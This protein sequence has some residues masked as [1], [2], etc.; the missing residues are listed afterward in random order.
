MGKRDREVVN[1]NVVRLM[2]QGAPE[3]DIRQYIS[4]EGYSPDT[5]IKFW[6]YP[7]QTEF[8]EKQVS[9]TAPDPMTQ[10]FVEGVKNVRGSALQGLHAIKSKVTGDSSAHDQFTA[11]EEYR[12]SRYAESP[13]GGVMRGNVGQAA[14]ES[15]PWLAIPQGGSTLLGRTLF[16]TGVGAAQGATDFVPEGGS[17]VDNTLLG[18]MFGGGASLFFEPAGAV[19]AK[20]ARMVQGKSNPEKA[21][22]PDVSNLLGLSERHKVSL[23]YPDINPKA[24]IAGKVGTTLESTPFVG[25]GDARQKQMEEAQLAA[26]KFKDQ[27]NLGGGPWQN[28]TAVELEEKLNRLQTTKKAYYD[29]AA[30]IAQPI[31]NLPVTNTVQAIDGL[32]ASE[33]KAIAPNSKLISTLEEWKAGLGSKGTTFND[34]Q[35]FQDKIQ[36]AIRDSNAPNSLMTSAATRPL[37][38]VKSALDKDIKGNIPSQAVKYWEQADSIV[39]NKLEPFRDEIP[40]ILGETD[41]DKQFRMI[42]GNLKG[43]PTTIYESLTPKGRDAVRYGLLTE[44][45][46]TA[47]NA[48]GTFSPA[49]FAK[50]V[51]D[52]RDMADVFFQGQSKVELDGFTKLMRAAQRGGQYMENPP[53]GNRLAVG[54]IGGVGAASAAGLAAW[55][56]EN[57]WLAGIAGATGLGL[58]FVTKTLFTTDAGKKFLVASAKFKDDDPK[59]LK[60]LF[61]SFAPRI[62]QEFLAESRLRT[63]YM[64]QEQ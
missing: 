24:P 40:K 26:G 18:T 5:D 16:N 33:Q 6:Q 23:Q 35:E 53:T 21:Y 22:G 30:R 46:N 1:R 62:A 52:R 17:R 61:Q 51:E 42:M 48:N 54:L 38:S 59:A 58:P 3:P 57:P 27:F 28:Q 60:L 50:F 43:K 12:R 31:G 29:A 20:L 44:A 9:P 13:T 2:K 19:T 32:I 10:G 41:P 56:T 37:Q 55:Y 25:T 8:F 36:A 63:Q 47:T 15:L 7:S 49:K 4:E 45:V 14:G 64:P 11:E 34:L 39:K